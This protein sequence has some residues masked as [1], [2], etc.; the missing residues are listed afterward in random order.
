MT[1]P[2]T[3]LI[4]YATIYRTNN[5]SYPFLPVVKSIEASNIYPATNAPTIVPEHPA[6]L[7]NP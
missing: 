2:N 4:I 3:V 6:A 1:I 5:L 7:N